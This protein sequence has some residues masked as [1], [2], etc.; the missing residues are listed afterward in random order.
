MTEQERIRI[1]AKKDDLEMM[2]HPEIWPHGYILPLVRAGEVGI[3]VDSVHGDYFW[4]PNMNLFM[5]KAQFDTCQKE[6]GRD[7]MLQRLIKEGW[8]VD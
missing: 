7:E 3:L 4:I 6:R 8:R 1:T 2:R 5:M